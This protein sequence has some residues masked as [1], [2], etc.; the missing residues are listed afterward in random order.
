MAQAV[1]EVRWLLDETSPQF[2]TNTMLK[3]WLNQACKDVSR[4]TQSLWQ[5]YT[6]AATPTKANYTLPT[7]MLG[8]HKLTFL[9]KTGGVSS[10]QWFNLEYRGIKQM[11]EIWGILHQLPAAYPN[12]FYIWNDVTPPGT[13]WY[14]GI[15]PVP[16]TTGTFILYYYRASKTATTTGAHLDIVQGYEDVAYEYAV[17]K[18]KRRD[19]D[20]TWQTAKQLYDAMLLNMKDQTSRFSDEAN[21]F[22]ND[23]NAQWPVYLYS[24][25]TGW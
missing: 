18:A 3:A 25:P 15:Y 10:Q 13:K 19:R 21:Q 12:A 2:W 17:Y 11:D 24:N 22:V 9:I 14:V 16:A 4:V 1:Q 8:V 20:P 6:F 7:D 23:A 5:T